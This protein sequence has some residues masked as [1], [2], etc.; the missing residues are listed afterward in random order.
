MRIK[1]KTCI[2]L[3]NLVW[4]AKDDK[5]IS[6]YYSCLNSLTEGF[7]DKD[8]NLTNLEMN[9]IYITKGKPNCTSQ[10]SMFDKVASYWHVG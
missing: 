10:Y 9:R 6:V 8:D 2:R 1:K 3:R 4:N 5:R 7:V